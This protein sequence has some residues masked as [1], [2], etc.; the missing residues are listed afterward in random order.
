MNLCTKHK[1]SHR[2]Q[3]Q[4]YGDQSGKLGG[5][6]MLQVSHG[7]TTIYKIDNQ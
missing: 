7:H 3:K 6:G 1:Q 5:K 2:F 4:I